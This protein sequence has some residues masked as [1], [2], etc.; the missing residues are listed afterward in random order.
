MSK[1]AIIILAVSAILCAC[2]PDMAKK[3]IETAVL[4]QLSLYPCL[5]LQDLYK[6]FFQAEFGAEHIVADTASAGRYLD[7]EL[8]L[9]DNSA[10]LFEPVGADSAFFRVHLRSVREGYISRDELF[11]AFLGGVNTVTIPQID[12]WKETWKGIE[13]VI[14]GM[15]LNLEG[16]DA[17]KEMIDSV[18]ASGQYAIHHSEEFGKQYDPHYRIVRKDLFYDRLFYFLIQ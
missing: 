8:G 17:D 16:Y 15:N 2:T 4:D 13:Q 10:V 7:Y 11:S 18:L 5:T 12:R 14:D 6:A 3:K 9:E 1:K